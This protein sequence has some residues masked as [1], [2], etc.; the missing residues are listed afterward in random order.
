MCV[1][2]HQPSRSTTANGKGKTQQT[3]VTVINYIE[4][5][6]TVSL[7]QQTGDESQVKLPMYICDSVHHHAS[8]GVPPVAPTEA[9]IPALT[10]STSS[11]STHI[12]C[13]DF[14]VVD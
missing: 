11:Q 3:P 8:L 1:C 4:A 9:Q 6:A 10:D 7:S 12:S 14:D 13:G 2:T 5:G